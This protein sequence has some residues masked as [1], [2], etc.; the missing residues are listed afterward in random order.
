[1]VEMF[2]DIFNE[3]EGGRECLPV[4]TTTAWK[5][6]GAARLG[7]QMEQLPRLTK[8]KVPQRISLTFYLN[9]GK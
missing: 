5:G 1:V 3:G 7:Y 2:A 6:V 8:L 4:A 9:F